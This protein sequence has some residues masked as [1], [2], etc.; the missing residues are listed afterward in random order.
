MLKL[1]VF[2]TYFSSVSS[3]S[4][5]SRRRRRRGRRDFRWARATSRGGR[6]SRRGP[7]GRSGRCGR[8]CRACPAR[9]RPRGG[10]KSC[11][12]KQEIHETFETRWLLEEIGVHSFKRKR[13]NIYLVLVCGFLV[14]QGKFSRKMLQ[15]GKKWTKSI[16]SAI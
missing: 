3:P 11:P 1:D 6:P 15:Q 2:L 7:A 13:K 16:F 9:S 8:P 4:S 5:S 12:P 10:G 14:S